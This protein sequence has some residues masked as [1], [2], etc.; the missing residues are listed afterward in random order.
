MDHTELTMLLLQSEVELTRSA[1]ERAKRD[2][3][4]VVT[5]APGGLPHPD[6]TQR[7]KVAAQRRT[8]AMAAYAA[9]LKRF[10]DFLLNGTIPDEL[11]RP[12]P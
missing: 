2:L 3:D 7:I 10:N 1:Y 11:K 12:R 5:E 9:S 8:K 4:C 6:A